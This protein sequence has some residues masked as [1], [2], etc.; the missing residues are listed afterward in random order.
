MHQKL[1][2]LKELIKGLAEQQP[3]LKAM[4]KEKLPKSVK[5]TI[6]R[7]EPKS[8]ATIV[9]NN[10]QDLRNMHI[11]YSLLL[12]REYKEIEQKVREGNEPDWYAIERLQNTY[13]PP[14]VKEEEVAEDEAVRAIA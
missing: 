10:K 8:A 1:L 14:P 7:V 9:R 13:R 12:G 5:L 11:A 4:R 6:E 2:E 3:Q